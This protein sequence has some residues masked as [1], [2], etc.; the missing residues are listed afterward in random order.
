MSSRFFVSRQIT[1]SGRLLGVFRRGNCCPEFD[2]LEHWLF[3][4]ASFRILQKYYGT[5]RSA[6]PPFPER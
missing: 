5:A 3:P 1:L 4:D 2:R 6:S